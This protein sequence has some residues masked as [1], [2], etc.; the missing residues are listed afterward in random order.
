[1]EP[2]SPRLRSLMGEAMREAAPRPGTRERALNRMLAT[3][4]TMPPSGAGPVTTTTTGKVGGGVLK[5]LLAV[6]SIGG[7][8][9]VGVVAGGSSSPGPPPRVETGSSHAHAEVPSAPRELA[10][11]VAEPHS[12]TAPAVAEPRS[13]T[14]PAH[15]RPP[16]STSVTPTKASAQA[17]RAAST[18]GDDLA[19]E[20]QWIASAHAALVRGD[21]QAALDLA[22]RHAQRFPH[23]QLK[24][25]RQAVQLAARC[26]LD[27]AMRRAAEV[28]HFLRDHGDHAVARKVRAACLGAPDGEGG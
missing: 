17:P 9:A 12:G 3:L 6:A 7:A 23:G 27:P 20:T 13:G 2:L 4:S 24:L 26:M 22:T 19:L 14:G 18:I 10:P 11:A 16:G 1:M 28:E 8:A 5:I 25:E 21:G 15:A